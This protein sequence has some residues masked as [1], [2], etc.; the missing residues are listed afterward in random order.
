MFSTD[1]PSRILLVWPA[2]N[3][4]GTIASWTLR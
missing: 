2:T 1:T 3:A 4:I